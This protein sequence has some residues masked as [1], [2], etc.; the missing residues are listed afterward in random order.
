M[1]ARRLPNLVLD[2]WCK[3]HRT[4]TFVT[5]L[6][7]KMATTTYRKVKRTNTA[8]PNV[9][10]LQLRTPLTVTVSE[11]DGLKG[12]WNYIVKH[13]Q[14]MFAETQTPS[15][16]SSSKIR[17]PVPGFKPTSSTSAH[18]TPPLLFHASNS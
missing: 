14:E 16:K 10:L 12:G 11:S 3:C 15:R 8:C 7:S 1:H 18:P 5:F 17:V 6:V 9:M 2:C 13:A 4:K